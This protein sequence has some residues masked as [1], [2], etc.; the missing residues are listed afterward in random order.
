ME[1]LG[2]RENYLVVD[3]LQS[4]AVVRLAIRLH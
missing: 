1:V 2:N 4:I 3:H